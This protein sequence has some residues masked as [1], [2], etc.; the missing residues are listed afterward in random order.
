MLPSWVVS[1]VCHVP[2]GAHPSFAMGFSVRDNAFYKA[3]DAISKDLAA[4]T[5][6]IDTHVRATSDFAEFRRS[7]GLGDASRV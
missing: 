7:A 2:N 3:W 1:A 6:W 5:A 4:F